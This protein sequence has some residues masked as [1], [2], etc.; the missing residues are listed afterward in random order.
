MA[1]LQI[2]ELPEGAGDD[3]APFVLVVDQMPTDDAAFDQLR[4]DLSDDV[5]A[6]IGARAVLAFEG[7]IEIPANDTSAYRAADQPETRVM[8]GDREVANVVAPDALRMRVAN[9]DRDLNAR[10]A[11]IDAHRV[12]A[13]AR[14][15]K[16]VDDSWRIQ[17][18][19]KTA[20]LD[21]LGM[22]RT[23]DWDDIRNAAAGLRKQRDAQA[24]ELEQLRA[25]EESGWDHSIVPTPGQYIARWNQVTPEKRLSM[26]AEIIEGMK[27]S[28]ECLMEDHAGRIAQLRA[29]AA[30]SADA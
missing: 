16:F 23:R 14:V 5:A 27:R 26:A 22:D 4:T 7:G 2:L 28:S 10:E 1:R 19:R 15:A 25:G 6:R 8:L 21:A 9:Q 20:L 11:L 24:T 12:E 29:E 30:R 17:Q 18:E 3:R 13:D